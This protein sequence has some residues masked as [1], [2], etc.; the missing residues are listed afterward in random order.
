MLSGESAQ[1]RQLDRRRSLPEPVFITD[2]KHTDDFVIDETRFASGKFANVYH[3]RPKKQRLMS[4][5]SGSNFSRNSACPSSANAD[6]DIRASPL[7]GSQADIECFGPLLG[8]ECATLRNAT[9][10]LP[11]FGSKIPIFGP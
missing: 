11:I 3:V 5:N 10:R 1:S 2:R 8:I 4:K 9:L 6:V 7:P